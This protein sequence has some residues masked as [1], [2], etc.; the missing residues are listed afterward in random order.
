MAY[1]LMD[2]LR[3]STVQN[4]LLKRDFPLQVTDCV[5]ELGIFGVFV[6]CVGPLTNTG[7]GVHRFRC[8]DLD[9]VSLCTGTERSW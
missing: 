7:S 1:I 4:I 8:V 6:R 9:R 3:P 5:S 2:K